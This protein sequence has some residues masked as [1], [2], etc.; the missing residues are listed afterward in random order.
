[1]IGFNFFVLHFDFSSAFRDPDPGCVS[2]ELRLLV[3]LPAVSHKTG[4]VGFRRILRGNRHVS[5][6][7]PNLR[8]DVSDFKPKG[9]ARSLQIC[10]DR[11]NTKNLLVR[12][13]AGGGCCRSPIFG[14]TTISSSRAFRRLDAPRQAQ[15]SSRSRPHQPEAQAED[16]GPTWPR[17]RFGVVRSA[18]LRSGQTPVFICRIKSFF[19]HF[20]FPVFTDPL[21][22]NPAPS[23]SLPAVSHKTGLVGFRREPCYRFAVS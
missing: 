16:E 9:G 7:V 19:L 14:L 4:L 1:M 3:S 22:R 15:P 23:T 8:I 21:H 5:V 18:L 20:D 12:S 10:N 17:W 11:E 2:P 13:P 6:E